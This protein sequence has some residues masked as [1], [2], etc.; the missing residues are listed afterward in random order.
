MCILQ[1]AHLIRWLIRKRN[2]PTS[3][4]RDIQTEISD[5]EDDYAI[6]K[7]KQSNSRVA[8]VNHQ[9]QFPTISV[10]PVIPDYTDT[11]TEET[12]F[13]KLDQTLL[14]DPSTYFYLPIDSNVNSVRLEPGVSFLAYCNNMDYHDTTIPVVIP[15]G[16]YLDSRGQFT[17]NEEVWELT[18][19]KCK[20]TIQGNNLQGIGFSK[21]NVETKYRDVNGERG[22]SNF[23]V[24]MIT[25]AFTQLSQPGQIKFKF[26]KFIVHI[27]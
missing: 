11:I 27:I 24:D 19:P 13:N 5:D 20:Q 2:T 21:C 8:R 22:S 3:I 18:C 7:Q 17:L 10:K 1:I 23:Q 14:I 4:A 26:V 16:Y 25:F 15:K 6:K 9:P 12:I